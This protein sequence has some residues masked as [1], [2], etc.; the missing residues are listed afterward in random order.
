MKL[1]T[2]QLTLCAVLTAMALA[3]S[4]LENLFRVKLI[5]GDRRAAADIRHSDPNAEVPECLLKFDR[6]ILKFLPRLSRHRN[7]F[8]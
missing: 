4:Y 2:K 5:P 1:T 3:L 7:T 8:L 6:G